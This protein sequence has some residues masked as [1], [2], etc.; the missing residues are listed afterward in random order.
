MDASGAARALVDE[1]DRHR[2]ARNTR[3]LGIGF[4][5]INGVIAVPMFATGIDA[6]VIVVPVVAVPV[7]AACSWLAQKHSDAA[8]VLLNAILAIMLF[9]GV[10]AN[11]Q[12]GPGPAFMGFS[13]FV[14]AATLPVRGVIAMG[15]VGALAVTGMWWVARDVPQLVIQPGAALTY[16]VALSTVTTILSVVQALN[17]RRALAQV[18]E[19]EQRAQIAEARAREIAAQL[20]QAQKMDALGRMAAS[21][22][23]DFNNF[24]AVILGA[25]WMANREL[26]ESS[27]GR[28]ALGD[29]KQATDSSVALTKRLLAFA[30][31]SAVASE[32]IDARAALSGLVD[33][34][35][36]ALGPDVRLDVKL[37]DR[38][39]RIVAEP[40]QLEQVILNLAVNARDAMPDGGT[41][42]VRARTRELAEGEEIDRAPG[43][44]L[45]LVVSDTG[46]GMTEEVMAHLFEPFFTTKAAGAGTGLGLS[47]CYA[48][49]RQLGGGIRATSKPGAGTTFTVLLPRA[50][51]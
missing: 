6:R 49:V 8:A 23:H 25:I 44:W 42:S 7:F 46:S 14:A 18:V 12:I 2:R 38:L 47:T 40:A 26:P 3:S 45:E 27:K 31:K 4:A 24:L 50:A 20:Q 13:L 10:A 39:P 16:G 48:I 9:A 33:L 37:D 29:A 30:R 1:L 34:L 32:A 51:G 5:A 28:A 17:T 35:P 22:A 41:L 21:V 36:R 43:E 19:R 11:R 15:G